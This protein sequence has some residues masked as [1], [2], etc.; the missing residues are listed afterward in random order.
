MD[1]KYNS[2]HKWQTVTVKTYEIS[3][4]SQRRL[5]TCSLE[6]RVGSDGSVLTMESACIGESDV[7]ICIFSYA[8]LQSTEEECLPAA[9]FHPVI[10]K[11]L[12]IHTFHGDHM[13]CP[14]TVNE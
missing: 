14:S 1:M 8:I 6:E 4:Q 5:C 3:S 10:R 11:G 13:H 9:D 2:K 7:L 12:A